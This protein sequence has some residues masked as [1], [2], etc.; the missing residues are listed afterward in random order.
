MAEPTCIYILG[1]LLLLYRARNESI[2]VHLDKNYFHPA[3]E[4]F[5]L[6]KEAGSM[7][8]E[9]IL[10]SSGYDWELSY[11]NYQHPH[12]APTRWSTLSCFYSVPE[13]KTYHV[14]KLMYF[15]ISS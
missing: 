7:V 10:P 4:I 15:C 5:L 6:M 2:C 11:T 12:C 8:T 14:L 9:S 3:S 1:H 13:T